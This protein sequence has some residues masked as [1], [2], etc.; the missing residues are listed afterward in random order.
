LALTAPVTAQVAPTA[1]PPAA[2]PAPPAPAPPTEAPLP[3]VEIT[4][5]AGKIVVR[6]EAKRAPKT[7][8][9]FLK[10]VDTKKY[11][12]GEFYRTTKN[13]GPGASLVQGGVNP[14]ALRL[15][16]VAHEPTNT[17][18][19]THCVGALSMARG[20]PGSA[21]SDFFVMLSPIKDFDAKPAPAD[22]GFAVFGEVVSGL[23]VAQAIFAAPVDP[24]KGDGVMK[25]QMITPPVKIISMRRTLAKVDAV[26]PPPKSCFAPEAVPVAPPAPATATKTP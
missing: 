19:L 18:G 6:L 8:A 22:P 16:A 3:Q 21:T 26:A 14:K 2:K 23:D 4:T 11:D 9:N 13:W 24:A 5:S 7:V 20:A 17:S 15:P 10:Y 25:G 1:K 12:G